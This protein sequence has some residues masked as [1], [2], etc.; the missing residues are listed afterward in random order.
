MEL[1]RHQIALGSRLLDLQFCSILPAAETPPSA[2]VQI[3]QPSIGQILSGKV[4]VR[5]KIITIEKART[6]EQV[7]CLSAAV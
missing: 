1:P 3:I 2:E 4:E 7:W 6:P 5:V